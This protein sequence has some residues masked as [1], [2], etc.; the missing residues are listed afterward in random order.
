MVSGGLQVYNAGGGGDGMCGPHRVG[1]FGRES[2]DT[3]ALTACGGP[4]VSLSLFLS[5]PSCSLL[6]TRNYNGESKR[7]LPS[8]CSQSGRKTQPGTWTVTV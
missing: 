1:Q 7:F 8:D 4:W 3:W 6:C 5:T 2:R